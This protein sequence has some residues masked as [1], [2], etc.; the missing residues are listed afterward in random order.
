MEREKIKQDLLICSIERADTQVCPYVSPFYCMVAEIRIKPY[1][2]MTRVYRMKE[3]LG[4]L[5]DNSK[6]RYLEVA[7]SHFSMVGNSAND[8]AKW[9]DEL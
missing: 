8:I 7:G 3:L 2:F 1:L 5:T 6:S 9:L 4:L